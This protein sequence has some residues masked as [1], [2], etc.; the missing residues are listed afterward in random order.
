MWYQGN[1][2]NFIFTNDV[3]TVKYMFNF[4]VKFE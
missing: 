3:E 1:G 4:L 2:N